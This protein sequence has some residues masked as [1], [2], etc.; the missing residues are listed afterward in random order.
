[1]AGDN[2]DEEATLARSKAQ[3]GAVPPAYLPLHKYL[4]NR[5]ADIVVLAF[6]EIED[7]LGSTLPES[8]RL[9]QSWWANAEAGAAPSAQARSWTNADRTARANLQAQRVVFER[10]PT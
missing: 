3:S 2:H 10:R 8:A 5:Y 6:S 4:K 1:M 9:Q 7:L